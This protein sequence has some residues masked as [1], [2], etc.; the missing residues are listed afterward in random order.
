M[1]GRFTL[2]QTPAE[3][4]EFFDL[5]RVAEFTPRFNIAPTQ[6]APVS[7]FVNHVRH[8]SPEYVR[9]VRAQRGLF[10]ESEHFQVFSNRNA[11]KR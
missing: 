5:F 3:L 4:Q 2:S 8:D 1:C 11:Y 9:P 10:D 7:S 6:R